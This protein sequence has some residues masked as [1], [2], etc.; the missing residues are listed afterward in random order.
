M[1]FGFIAA[2]NTVTFLVSLEPIHDTKVIPFEVDAEHN[3]YE[4]D[5]KTSGALHGSNGK[6]VQ[7]E[8]VV[9]IDSSESNI[10]SEPQTGPVSC[11]SVYTK[12]R[13]Y[14]HDQSLTA[15][16]ATLTARCK[17]AMVSLRHS[18]QERKTSRRICP[19]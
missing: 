2:S 11:L 7:I 4:E 3:S 5:F 16:T 12:K 13:R 18:Y 19:D 8:P 17:S 9:P 15:T 6:A 1:E 10:D 14:H